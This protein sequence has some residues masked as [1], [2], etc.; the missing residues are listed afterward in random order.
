METLTAA[1]RRPVSDLRTAAS[2]REHESNGARLCP[3]CFSDKTNERRHLKDA[4]RARGH[5]RAVPCPG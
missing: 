1:S 3:A 5:V 2:D 4:V